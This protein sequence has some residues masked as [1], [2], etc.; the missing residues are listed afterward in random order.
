MTDLDCHH[1]LQRLYEYLDGELSPEDALDVEHH[2]E[3]CAACYPEVRLTT[4]LRQALQRAARGQPCCPDGLRHRI[5]Q[6]IQHEARQ[7]P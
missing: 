3:I 1:A 4:E 6:L 7:T 5:A 2:L